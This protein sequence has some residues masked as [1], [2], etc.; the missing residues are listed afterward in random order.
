MREAHYVLHF[1]KKLWGAEFNASPVYLLTVAKSTDNNWWNW[2]K[3]FRIDGITENSL[4][5]YFRRL[6]DIPKVWDNNN[7]TKFYWFHKIVTVAERLIIV[8][9]RKKKK[10]NNI[11]IQEAT[12]SIQVILQNLIICTEV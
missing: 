1:H 3:C 8:M 9:K 11:S 4:I 2:Y 12:F 6:T 5:N 10:I 7:E